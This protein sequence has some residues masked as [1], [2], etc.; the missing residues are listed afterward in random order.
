MK[1]ERFQVKEG[2]EQD[3]RKQSQELEARRKAE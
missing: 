3:K 2:R 1:R